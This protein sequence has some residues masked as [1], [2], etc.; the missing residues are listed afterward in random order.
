MQTNLY[1]SSD[2]TENGDCKSILTL[3]TQLTR[4]PTCI[5]LIKAHWQLKSGK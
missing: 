3:P 5:R 2:K 1:T 4:L